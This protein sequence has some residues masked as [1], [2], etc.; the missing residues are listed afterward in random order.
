MGSFFGKFFKKRTRANSRENGTSKIPFRLNLIF[1][2]VGVLFAVLI[3][4]LADLQIIQ[5][6]YFKS[7]VNQSNNSTVYGNVQRGMIYDSTG[8]QIAG[9]KS[10]RAIIYTKGPGIT[11]D[12]MYQVATKLSSFIKVPAK[13]L[14]KK[15]IAE[16]YLANANNRKQVAKSI[17]NAANLSPDALQS[18]EIKKFKDGSVAEIT[19]SMKNA[20]TIYTEMSGAYQLSTTYI[21]YSGVSNKEVAEVGEH[22]SEMPGVQVGTSWKRSYPDGKGFQSITGTVSS[23]K[24]GLP[25]DRVNQLLAQ[26]YSQDE[27][28]GQSNL[29]EEYEP[30]LKGSKS[31]TDVKLNSNNQIVKQVKKYPGQRGD[32]L[33]L[34]INAKFQKD[35]QKLVKDAQPGGNATGTYAVAMNPNTGAVI[36]MAGVSRDPKTNKVTQNDIGNINNA[37]TMGSVVKGAT[38]SGALMDHVITP[39]NSTMTD[40]PIKNGGSSKSSWFNKTG[41]AN[42][43]VTASDALEVSSN[44]YMMQLAMKEA[45]FKYVPGGQL[46]MNPNIFDIERG[47]FN[48]FGLGIKTGIDLPGE[49]A[50]IK[51]PGGFENIGKAL[52]ESYGNYDG[53][54]TMQV[55]QYMSTIANGGYRLKPH[56]VQNI[57]GTNSKTGKLGAVKETIMPQ[58]L[59]E[60]PMTEDERN[61][62]KDG[63][64]K[65]VHGNNKYKTGGAL[66]DISP[67]ISAK[68]G[69][70]QT[71]YN[72]KPTVTLSLASYAP[73]TH[74]QVVVALAMPNLPTDAESNNMDL[75]KNIYKAYWKDVQNKP[76]K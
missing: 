72:G 28:V 21:K 3:W 31:Q 2:I 42:M 66:A 69:T 61:V 29:E 35:L 55:A 41:N 56:V 47:Y 68:T 8:K 12:E 67:E 25:E 38:V 11:S 13:K 57:R 40:E 10:E 44:S 62:V 65:V 64:Y 7:N 39:T 22:Q 33:Q 14:T 20:A 9:N 58:A 43:P 30:I 37:I 27:S 5:G 34:T 4:K 54:T 36:G 6:N 45:K 52:D 71:F 16:Y 48:Q 32:N 63:L 24:V 18:S 60:I 76:S 26:G 53:Y 1:I 17:P 46:N 19:P 50:G 51:G 59:N 15:Q 23:N 70:A 49:S 75:A 74:P 73:S